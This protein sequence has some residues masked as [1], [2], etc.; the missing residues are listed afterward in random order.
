[1]VKTKYH[2]Q[3]GLRYKD[4]LTSTQDFHSDRQNHSLHIT[5]CV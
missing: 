3:P 4:A 1:M 5:T 2:A